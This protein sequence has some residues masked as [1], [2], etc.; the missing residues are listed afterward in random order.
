MRHYF[1]IIGF[2][3]LALLL[4]GAPVR[5]QQEETHLGKLMRNYSESEK[6]GFAYYRLARLEPPL[7]SWIDA[8]TELQ[9]SGPKVRYLMRYAERERLKTGFLTYTPYRDTIT[10]RTTIRLR[11]LDNPDQKAQASGFKKA[12]GINFRSTDEQ[13]YFPFQLG[14]LWIAVQPQGLTK[15]TIY[16]ISNGDYALLAQHF[17]PEALNG[18]VDITAEIVTLPLRAEIL[19]PLEIGDRPLWPLT[20]EL[21]EIRLRDADD[22]IVWTATAEKS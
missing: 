6:I 1:F 9:N 14:P 18:R 15:E 3:A 21:V 13:I 11:G 12:I 20:M 4:P 5:A 2:V 10:L 16:S 19:T 22:N 17:G 8:N 7:E